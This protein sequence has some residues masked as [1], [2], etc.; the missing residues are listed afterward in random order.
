MA[1]AGQRRKS[2]ALRRRGSCSGGSSPLQL[3]KERAEQERLTR[4]RQSSRRTGVAREQYVYVPEGF[5]EDDHRGKPEIRWNQIGAE[6]AKQDC[7]RPEEGQCAESISRPLPK[8][9][10]RTKRF[11]VRSLCRSSPPA[12]AS[13]AAA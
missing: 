7:C 2:A 1:A 4:K 6:A 3:Q 12:A 13:A 9:T 8:A 5:Y 11:S 10:T